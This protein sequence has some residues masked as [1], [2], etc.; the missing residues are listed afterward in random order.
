MDIFNTVLTDN[1]NL[2]DVKDPQARLQIIAKDL[3]YMAYYRLARGMLH[4]DRIVLAILLTKIY[5]KG[6]ATKKSLDEA[7]IIESHYRSLMLP[8]RTGLAL[9]T[10]GSLNVE[11]SEALSHLVK[12][13][14]FKALSSN[15]DENNDQFGKWLEC[16]KPEDVPQSIWKPEA[17]STGSHNNP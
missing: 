12:L 6:F 9:T 3:F 16:T 10:T 4:D 1:A 2:K 7:A 8:Y 14:G 5:L 17:D 11:H 13:P 15:I